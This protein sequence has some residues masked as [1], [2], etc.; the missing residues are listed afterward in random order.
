MT[1]PPALTLELTRMLPAAPPVVFKAFTEPEALAGWW[2]PAGFTVPRLRFEPRAGERYRIEMQP[3]DGEPFFLTGAFREVAPPVRLAYSFVW[4]DS[5]PDD[6]ETEVD[7]AF[8]ALGDATEVALAH[9]PFRTKARLA[10]HRNGW[11]E[12]LAK[13]ERRLS[14]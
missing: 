11:T 10:L 3:P 9:G 4:E 7:L 2:G 1:D 5:D 6:V 13:L 8:R 12:A 14:R